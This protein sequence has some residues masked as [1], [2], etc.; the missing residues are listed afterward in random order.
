VMLGPVA[1]PE[2]LLIAVLRLNSLRNLRTNIIDVLQKPKA[3]ERGTAT[4]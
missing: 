4:A 3:K 1:L 2:L